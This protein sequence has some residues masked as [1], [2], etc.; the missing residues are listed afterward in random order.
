MIKN[1]FGLNTEDLRRQEMAET[2]QLAQRLSKTTGD[3]Y[4]V[5]AFGTAFGKAASKGLLSKMG[6]EDP[7]LT[8][9]KENEALQEQFD[10]IDKSTA[11]GNYEAAQ[12]LDKAGRPELAVQYRN[13]ALR[14]AEQSKKIRKKVYSTIPINQNDVVGSRTQRYQ[15]FF[16]AEAYEEAE[17]EMKEIQK[18]KTLPNI[19]VKQNKEIV[20]NV[21]DLTNNANKMEDIAERFDNLDELSGVAGLAAKKW[22]EFSGTEDEISILR[23][24]WRKIR[25]DN[26]LD[27]LPPGAASDKDVQIVLGAFL[28]ENANGKTAAKF[29]R[30]IAKMNKIKA[31]QGRFR[32]NYIKETKGNAGYLEAWEAYKKSDAFAKKLKELGI[33]AKEEEEATTSKPVKNFKIINGKIIQ[34]K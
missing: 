33:G 2:K 25:A 24:D 28:S 26:T 13:V 20:D 5:T 32:V 4:G 11:Q 3:N 14:M 22:K 23:A 34:N 29:L 10:N 12:L 6:Y 21:I 18:Y 17:E 8:Q 16:D 9:A 27:N 7:A 1:I 31:E 19:L 15:Q 30:G